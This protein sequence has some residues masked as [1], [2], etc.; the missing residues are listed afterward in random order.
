MKNKNI[1]NTNKFMF[2]K[3]KFCVILSLSIQCNL[4]LCMCHLFGDLFA[5]L[6]NYHDLLNLNYTCNYIGT[7]WY[8]YYYY[9][10]NNV[11]ESQF[12]Q[13]YTNL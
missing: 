13:W 12:Y 4:I 2:D 10:P 5:D 8:V 7:C 3:L 11:W 6:L 9:F 1:E